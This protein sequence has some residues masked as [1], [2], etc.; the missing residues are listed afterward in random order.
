MTHLRTR[1]GA[2]SVLALTLPQAK[3]F[4][5]PI[6]TLGTLAIPLRYSRGSRRPPL[7][8]TCTLQIVY[9]CAKPMCHKLLTPLVTLH[10]LTHPPLRFRTRHRTKTST[11]L[12]RL[13]AGPG[14]RL[15]LLV[16]PRPL[17][18]IAPV[19]SLQVLLTIPAPLA[20]HRLHSTTRKAL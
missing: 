15:L 1:G 20:G 16:Q 8:P 17:S 19:P 4:R 7:T 18:S 3:P 5:L 13:P 2:S 9:G 11:Y 14:F 12:I 6:S 10:L